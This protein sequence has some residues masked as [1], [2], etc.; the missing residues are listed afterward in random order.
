MSL[1][2]N[3]SQKRAAACPAGFAVP[4]LSACLIIGNE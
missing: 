2:L 3:G 4:V 1:P